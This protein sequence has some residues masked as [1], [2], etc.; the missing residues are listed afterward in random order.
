MASK[1]LTYGQ[2]LETNNLIR[3]AG[4]ET[5]FL[6]VT[7][8]VQ[9]S[10]FFPVSAYI[11]LGYLNAF[12]RYPPLLRKISA[13]MSPED[14]ADRVRNSNSKIQSMGTNWCMINFYLLGRE[15]MIDMGLIRPQDAADD[16]IFVTDFWRRYQLAWRRESGHITNK[17]AGHRSQVLPE[18]RIQVYHADMY[19]CE[20]GDAL[21]TAADKFLAAVSQFAVLVA[22][23][24]RVCMTNHGPYNLGH[25]RE[26]LVRDFFDLG[27]GDLPWLDGVAADVPFSRLTVPTAVK[28]THF[29]VVDDW[30]SFD[31]KP[32][33]RASNI[34]AVGLYTSDELSE[35]QIPVGMGSREELVDTFERYADIFKIATKS[36][37]ER[38]ASYSREQL[39]DAGALTYYSIIKDFAHVAGCYEVEDWMMIDPRADRFRPLLNDEYGNGLLGALFVPLSLAS[40]Q[41]NEYEMMPHSNLPKRN[42]SPIPYSVLLDGDY[43]PS[44]GDIVSPG[45]TYLPHKVDRY[46]TTEGPMTLATLN[47]RVR[48]F[49]P[50]LCSERFRFLDDAWVKYNYSSP[51]A[52]ELYHIEQQS[53]RNLSGRGAGLSRDEVEALSNFAGDAAESADEGSANGA[54]A[55]LVMHGIGIKKYADVDSITGVVGLPAELVEATINKLVERSLAASINDKVTLTPAGRLLM[56]TSFSRHYA[57]IRSSSKFREGY[58]R[59][60]DI[61]SDLKA[62]IT[63][64]QVRRIGGSDFPNDHTDRE[65]DSAVIDSLGR[66][67][68]RADKVFEG[69]SQELPRLRIYRDK[70]S[71]ALEKAEDG[72]TEWVSDVKIES[73]HTVWFELHEDLLC[74]LGLER[75]EKGRST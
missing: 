2:L 74:L 69:L 41:F 58:V 55:H 48:A 28:N 53:S 72:A 57:D 39:M 64:W 34:C 45:I 60:E 54:V 68:D 13:I 26:L 40:Q 36:L 37:W 22:C 17:E 52:N 9:E 46:R 5:Y 66:L 11:M 32:E 70:L 19:P 18:R 47:E 8:T 14:L 10:K 23:E 44:V 61:N 25:D 73:Y 56:A 75:E 63:K 62:L 43:A 21:H 29:Y 30:G 1:L 20:E 71:Y 24:S 33:Y 51:L 16:V 3:T 7:R 31:S 4:E 59:F 6:G 12:Y 27:E 65:Y 49:T 50:Q 15:M 38:L 42:Y 35:T 67:H